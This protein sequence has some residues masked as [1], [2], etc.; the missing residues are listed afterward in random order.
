MKTLFFLLLVFVTT[1]STAQLYINDIESDSPGTDD[2][3]FIELY[4]TT[5]NT[6]LNGYVL[7]LFNGS[8]DAS[9]AAYDLDGYT[10]D[11][12]G[13]FVIGD[14]GVTGVMKVFSSSS[15]SNIQNGP[16]A[17]ALYQANGTDFPSDTSVTTTN[18]V[19]AVVYDNNHPDDTA[20]LTGLGKTTQF[21][22]DED[23]NGATNSLQRQSD[24]SFK[25]GT[26]SPNAGNQ[27]LSVLASKASAL[28]IYPNP[29]VNTLFI[30]GLNEDTT[31][32]VFSLTGQ[33]VLHTRTNHSVNLSGLV[34]GVY[35][36]E[37]IHNGESTQHKL[38]KH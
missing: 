19:D 3:E 15:S 34:S 37:I 14:T 2:A 31:V 23:D 18:L 13:Y 4:S 30:D 20:L 16:D 5:P 6:S 12:N 29:V 28:H 26:P 24:G 33:L 10:T 22:E 38:I 1:F 11:A 32:S 35:L 21:N 17:V 25:A 36:L 7:V 27:A 9:Y 8:D